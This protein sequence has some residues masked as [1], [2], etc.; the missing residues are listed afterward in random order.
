MKIIA[1]NIDSKEK[2]EVEVANLKDNDLSLLETF[3]FPENRNPE[4][5]VRK[6]IESQDISADQKA[7]IWEKL[8]DLAQAVLLVGKQVLSVGRK[9][10][11]FILHLVTKYPNLT[12]GLA[13]GAVFGSLIA[14]VPII[15]WLIGGLLQVFLPLIGGVIGFRED[16]AQNAFKRRVFDAINNLEVEK[17]I[18]KEVLLYEQLNTPD[19]SKAKNEGAQ[20]R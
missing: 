5:A 20:S 1:E 18:D 6:H 17:A 10:L 11:D 15:G 9:I 7:Q 2:R 14:S 19:Q 16:L 4:K 12:I 3:H 8:K 13:I